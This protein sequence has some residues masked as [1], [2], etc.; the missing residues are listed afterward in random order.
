MFIENARQDIIISKY[1]EDVDAKVGFDFVQTITTSDDETAL[2]DNALGYPNQSSP[3]ADRYEV[4]LFLTKRTLDS[5]DGDNFILLAKFERGSYVYLKSDSEYSDIMEMIAKRTF[6]TNGNYTVRPFKVRFI[7]DKAEFENDPNGYSVDGDEDYVRAVVKDGISYVKG[8]RFE[9]QGEQFLQMFKARD[10]QETSSFTKSFEDR[11]FI[12]LQPLKSYSAYPNDPLI[13][14]NTDGTVISVYDG[15]FSSGKLPTGS[16]IGTFRVYDAMPESSKGTINATGS[17]TSIEIT[18]QGSGYTA[19]PTVSFTGGVG[20]GAVGVA[21]VVNGKVV[22]VVMTTGGSGYEFPPTVTISGG[23][24]SGATAKAVITGPAVFKYYIYDLNMTGDNKLSD[25]LSFVDANQTHGFKAVPWSDNVTIYNPNK[26]ELI[27]KLDRDDI[28]SLRSIDDLENPNPP[29]SISIF[30]RKKMTGVLNGSGSLTFTS[31]TNEFFEPF[32]PNK[33]V[34][35]ITD[36]D[37]GA[38]IIH[39]VDLSIGSRFVRTPTS[40]TINLGTSLDVGATNPLTVPG[41]SITL[42]HNVLRVNAQEDSKVFAETNE[43]INV[44]PTTSD[45]ALG[46]ADA[47]EIIHVIQYNPATPGVGEI[48][49]TENFTLNKNIKDHAYKESTLSVDS[50]YVID[51]NMRWKY[52]IRY[53]DHNLSNNLGYYTVDSYRQLISDGDLNYED[54]PVHTAINK[55][56]YPLFGCF[57]FRPKIIGSTTIGSGV[58]VIGSTA[59]F[60]LQ[61]YLGRI[62]LLCVNKEGILYIKKGSPSDTPIPPRP[63]I[64]SMVL[65]EIHLSPYTYNLS[66]IKLKY[67]ENKR[68]TMRD[69][70]KLEERI[71]TIEYYTVLNLLEK[72]AEDMNIKDSDGLDRFK[73]GF[74]ADNFQN[75]Q[76]A[77]VASSDFKAALDRKKK[78]LRPSYT[79][80]NKRLGVVTEESDAKFLG[81]MAMID[82]DSVVIDNQPFATKHIS[83]N[84]HFQ[85]KKMGEMVLTPNN[86]VWSDVTR[87]PELVIDVD[88]GVDA[89]TQI[90]N[91]SGVLGTEW[92]AWSNLNSTIVN[93]NVRVTDVQFHPELGQVTIHDQ[94]TQTTSQRTGTTRTIESRTDSYDFGDRVVDVSINPY[95]RE[96]SIEF[97]ATKMKANTKIWAFFDKKPV[98]DSVRALKGV[99]GDQLI[100]DG[101]GQISGIFDCPPGVFFTGDREFYLTSDEKLT[102]DADLETTAAKATFFS[103]GL[104]VTKQHTTM[105]VVTPVMNAVAVSETQVTQE[106]ANFVDG[107]NF[108]P[109][110]TCGW[111]AG[112]EDPIAQSFRLDQEYFITGLD[113]YFKDIDPNNEEIFFQ[114]RTMVNGYPG[115]TILAEKRH[116]TSDLTKSEDSSIP[117]HV[118]FSFPTYVRANEWYCFVIGGYSPDT[119]AWVAKLGQEVVDIPGKIVETQPSIGSSFRSQNANTW[120]A[121]QYEDIKY[122]LYAAKFKKRDMSL[123]FEHIPERLRLDRDP[124]EGEATK[125]RIRV[126]LEDHGFN[127]NDKVTVSMLEDDWITITITDGVMQIGMKV[128]NGF[129]FE[130]TVT[131]YKVTGSVHQIKMKNIKGTFSIGQLFVCNQLDWNVHDNY[132]VSK[133]GY[134]S[135]DITAGGTVRFNQVAGTF[136]TGYASSVNGIPIEE[137]NKQHTIIEVDSMDSFIIQTTSLANADG[138]FGGEF[139]YCTA[140]EKYEIFNI[141]GAYLPYESSELFEYTGVG[142]N[143]LNGVFTGQDYQ[144]MPKREIR[145]GDDNYLGQPHKITSEDNKSGGGRYVVMD[146]SFVA[147][148]E[149]V[150]PMV[151]TDTFSITTVSNRVEWVEPN[152]YDVEPNATGRYRSESDPLNGS[153]NFKYVTKTINLKNP[154]SDLVIAFDVYKDLNSDFDLWL[155]VVAPYEGVDIDTKRWMRVVGV[156]KSHNSVDLFDRLDLEITMSQMQLDVYTTN[157]TFT[158][159]DWSDLPNDEFSS[160]KLKIVGRSKNPAK[161][162]LLQSLRVIAVT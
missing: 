136:V 146:A 109:C 38:G 144:Q 55:S 43:V 25:G 1:G 68:Y 58:P 62:D 112:C 157:D 125:N 143:P 24:G 5:E 22:S 160:F 82:F 155:K 101:S 12:Y 52:K 106:N 37:Q 111:C 57:D 153:E 151:N 28:K 63:D 159:I 15:P 99:K 91:A 50:S 59:I 110:P 7:E 158:T 34:A 96:T 75:Y 21:N 74:I 133:I 132:L 135:N 67:I 129:G 20:T 152:Q 113:V 41:N 145:M 85:Y 156:D 95:M 46:I 87:L 9:N 126:Y 83:I 54:G 148:N 32:D 80:R 147:P 149:W 161:P 84:P 29:G 118:E 19:A 27:W 60:D 107:L 137:L 31:Y 141:S 6:E 16:V 90:A 154:A 11:T 51:T 64:D 89:I 45:I 14:T 69:I 13:P 130:G 92:G 98:S 56:V 17:V 18:N 115:E 150:S 72:S 104:N 162:P 114:L 39:T 102:G 139:V 48:D 127:T 93:D 116:K 134:Q 121:E 30:L 47:V 142:H 105:N 65:Y 128:T 10:T 117:F 123:K 138:R 86:D 4:Q 33:T 131:D 94:T 44:V 124:F 70:G 88:T 35:V 108:I 78:E 119:R 103:G 140:N 77:D 76:A 8:Y 23:G 40:I 79:P 97:F 26:T 66:D 36:N 2:L 120:N 100:T 53:F 42:I 73:N 122:Q 61:Y 71:K 3:G 81:K 49:I